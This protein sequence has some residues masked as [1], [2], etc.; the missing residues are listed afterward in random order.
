MSG[1]VNDVPCM[2]FEANIFAK[3]LCQHCFRAAGAHQQ[4]VQVS[5][6][7]PH[8]SYEYF[9]KDPFILALPRPELGATLAGKG[10]ALGVIDP[11]RESR[12]VA[13]GFRVVRCPPR[14]TGL[15]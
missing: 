8:G 3:S 11:G 10:W 2:N 12:G 13:D 9:I 14:A 1:S 6:S 5:S 15:G 7:I 4:A